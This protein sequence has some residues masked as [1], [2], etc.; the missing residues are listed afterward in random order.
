MT[1]PD[2]RHATRSLRFCLRLQ[3]STGLPLIE[4]PSALAFRSIV[5]TDVLNF[6]AISDAVAP[7]TADAINSR[8]FFQVNRPGLRLPTIPTISWL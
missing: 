3:S 8:S 2:R 7:L 1:K 4:I 5:L 6:A